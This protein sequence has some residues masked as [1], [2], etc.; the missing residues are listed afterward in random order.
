MSGSRVFAKG[1]SNGF[2]LGFQYLRVVLEALWNRFDEQI[3]RMVRDGGEMHIWIYESGWHHHEW[4]LF[5][6]YEL[7]CMESE[8]YLPPRTL[9]I[10]FSFHTQ[11]MAKWIDDLW[12]L[13]SDLAV[14]FSEWANVTSY[15][16]DGI[17]K[18]RDQFLQRISQHVADF[19][20]RC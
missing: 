11:T 5:F 19:P 12:S 3:V 14:N 1:V 2:R 18:R 7:A 10:V 8:Q 17:W 6:A 15:G 13:S 20:A 9:S 16:F 4:Q